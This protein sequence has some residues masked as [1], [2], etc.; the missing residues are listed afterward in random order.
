MSSFVVVAEALNLRAEPSVMGRVLLVLRR[1][2]RV[3]RLRVSGDGY[4]F[5]VRTAAGQSG[6][7]AHKHLRA[8]VEPVMEDR[9][10]WMPIARAEIGI[11]ELPGPQDNPRI[12]EYLSSTTLAGPSRDNDETPWCSA[13]ANWCL[14]RAGYEGTDSAWARSWLTWGVALPVP[15]EGAVTVFDRGGAGG[16]VAFFIGETPSGIRVLGGNQRNQVTISE[17]PRS[18][19][20]GCRLPGHVV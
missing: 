10:P 6:W 7:A 16:H 4:W 2:D 13:F 18:R 11:K 17:Y 3:E 14:E 8:V 20:L 1:N 19:L 15:V 12:L 9:F 5:K